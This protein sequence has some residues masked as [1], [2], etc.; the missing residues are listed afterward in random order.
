[1]SKAA[2]REEKIRLEKERQQRR[3]L[4][5]TD[6]RHLSSGTAVTRIERNNKVRLN[7]DDSSNCTL[8]DFN[9]TARPI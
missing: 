2:L 5:T 7:G 9:M 3:V 8:F 6:F 4:N 1:M